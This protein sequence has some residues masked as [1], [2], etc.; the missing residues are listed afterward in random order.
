MQPWKERFQRKRSRIVSRFVTTKKDRADLADL[1]L[2]V[3]AAINKFMVRLYISW[4]ERV[5]FNSH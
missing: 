3:Q 4:K 5:I 2:K 1:A